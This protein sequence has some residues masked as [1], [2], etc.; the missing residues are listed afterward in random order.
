M[1]E[2]DIPLQVFQEMVRSNTKYISYEESIKNYIESGRYAE[3]YAIVKNQSV[4]LNRRKYYRDICAANG[5]DDAQYDLALSFFEAQKN[6]DMVFLYFSRLVSKGYI[7]AFYYLAV[8]YFH[9]YGCKIDLQSARELMLKAFVF[10]S[11][12]DAVRSHYEFYTHIKELF[13]EYMDIEQARN[14]F[15]GVDCGQNYQKA[16]TCFAGAFI[17]DEDAYSGCMLGNIFLNGL[18]VKANPAF[19]LECYKRCRWGII[20]YDYDDFF[21]MMPE[22]NIGIC[23]LNGIGTQQNKQRASYFLGCV[24][25][26]YKKPENDIPERFASEINA[27]ID[28]SDEL[29]SKYGSDFEEEAEEWFDAQIEYVSN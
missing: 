29:F 12:S 16:L 5:V 9:G 23:L 2:K 14:Y 10:K 24:A 25:D 7:K 13:D 8:C 17:K 18:G 20:L 11:W 22:Y 3:A 15:F 26:Y 28:I 4:P 19:A 6:Y 27:A 1:D 21:E